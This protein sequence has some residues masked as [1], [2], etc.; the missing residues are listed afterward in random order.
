MPVCLSANLKRI[1]GVHKL[2]SWQDYPQ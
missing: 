1:N 2:D